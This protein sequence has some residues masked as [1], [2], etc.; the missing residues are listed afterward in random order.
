MDNTKQIEHDAMQMLLAG[1]HPTLEMLR[2]QF[3]RSYVSERN[4]TG[5]G[6]F[7]TF[8]VREP[9]SRL[10]PP[11]RIVIDDVCA[12]V[13]GLETGCCFVL[14]V[15]DGLLGTLECHLWGDNALPKDAQYDRLFYIHQPNPPGIAETANRDMTSLN[16]KIAG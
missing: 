15:D 12:D 4:F 1:A 5:L 6:F 2:A 7:T 16:G 10:D 13:A 11:N 8:K 14:F 9:Y 3:E